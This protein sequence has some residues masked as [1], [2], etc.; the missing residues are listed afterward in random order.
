M[1][2]KKLIEPSEDEAMLEEVCHGLKNGGDW[3][4]LVCFLSMYDV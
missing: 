2:Y 4:F 1:L 3:Q